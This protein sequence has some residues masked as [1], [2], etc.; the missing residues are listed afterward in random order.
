MHSCLALSIIRYGP[1]VSGAI[2]G[3]ESC[4]G[5]RVKVCLTIYPFLGVQCKV[6]HKQPEFELKSI[7][8]RAFLQVPLIYIYIYIVTWSATER[9]EIRNFPYP[10]VFELTGLKRKMNEGQ[11]LMTKVTNPV[12]MYVKL[13]SLHNTNRVDREGDI[14][15]R[16]VVR[17]NRLKGWGRRKRPNDWPEP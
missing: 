12:R 5:E 7:S 13:S 15:V 4:Q 8:N 2:Q 16:I 10:S 1:S 17:M 14:D 3:R 9:S 11:L 6:K